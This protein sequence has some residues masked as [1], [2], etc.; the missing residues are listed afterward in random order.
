[1]RYLEKAVLDELSDLLGFDEVR[2][3]TRIFVDH[4]DVQVVELKRCLACSDIAEATR[5]AHGIK[6]SAANLGAQVLADA[7]AGIER[8][9]RA[10]DLAAAADVLDR[11][12]PIYDGTRREMQAHGFLDP[13]P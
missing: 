2:K 1:M 3:V 8:S 6:G 13:A 11:L 10:G 7:A 5:I 9:T 12:A 4:F